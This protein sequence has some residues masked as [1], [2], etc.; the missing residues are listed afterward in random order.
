MNSVD[1]NITLPEVK[2]EVD[3]T[4]KK[5]DF[6]LEIAGQRGKQGLSAYEIA[7]KNGFIGTEQE[8]LDSFSHSHSYL[9]LSGGTLTGVVNGVTPTAGDNSTKIATTE[10]VAKSIA[11]LVNG[12]P[13]Q[14]NT[15]NELAKALGNNANFAATMTAELAKKLNSTE[16]E[17][18]YATKTEVKSSETAAATSASAAKTSEQNAGTQANT[19]KAWATSTTSPDGAADTAS[20]TGKTQSAKS[21]ALYSKDRATA[22]ASSASAAAGSAGAAKT[23]ETNAA[24][25][26][27][28][29]ATS[30]TNAAN[31]AK[32]AAA[33]E[34]AAKNSATSAASSKDNAK[35]YM[36]NA[37]NYSEN[38]NVFIPS[39][40]SDG[41]LSWTNKAGLP[42]PASVNIKGA[43]GDQGLQGATGA[44]ATIR[45]GSV[46]TGAAGSNASV[47]NSGTTSDV[48]LNFTLP[49]GKDGTGG[50]GGTVTVDDELSD[51][52]TN[53]VQNKVVKMNLDAL[54]STAEGIAATAQEAKDVAQDA[55]D[56]AAASAKTQ[57][58]DWGS[59]DTS[60][61]AYIKNKPDV[62]LKSGGTATGN[63]IAPSF[64]TGNAAS[65]YF[66]CRKFRGEG[67]ADSYYHAIDFG[68]GGHNQVD[69]Y[70]YGGVWNFHKCISGKAG[71]STLV[72]AITASAGW[73]G[74]VKGQ[75]ITTY[76]KKTDLDALAS[77]A[78]PT[79]VVQAFA[80]STTPQGWLLCDGSA[81]SRT[82]YA[83]L[84]NAIGT[85]YGSGDGSSTFNLPKVQPPAL[86][87]RYI[88]K[89]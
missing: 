66:Q 41:V 68:Y 38:V 22:S 71:T 60:S 1:I 87:M 4:I 42:N 2:T 54:A 53:P 45:I 30:A 62:L 18:T 76:A 61:M 6:N 19:A 67:N 34:T 11:S 3:A 17:S 16:A 84:F 56:I 28:A 81:V 75:D 43:K 89:Y 47:T 27:T 20:T 72:G 57:Q 35:T 77:K 52:S 64:Q 15:L 32:A 74:L 13:D 49:R 31:S 50:G 29:A 70:E 83:A 65:N 73:N 78:V 46:T 23:S 85:T 33:S 40:S 14:L 44:A 5:V 80:G 8:W 39:V 24:S 55:K 26:K 63:I 7:V 69:F 21:W 9:P 86:T 36:D 25:S 10:F 82:D 88:I 12:A 37:K 51:T 48:V 79:G 58:S 59:T